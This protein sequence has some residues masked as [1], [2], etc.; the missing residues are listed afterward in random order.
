MDLKATLGSLKREMEKEVLAARKAVTVSVREEAEALKQTLRSQ[1]INA[2]LGQRVARAWRGNSYPAGRESLNAAA[3][4]FS[5]VPH[6]IDAY[7]N[8]PTIRSPKGMLAIPLPGLPKRINGKRPTPESLEKAWGV[9]LRPVFR[10]GKP[11]LLVIDARASRGKRGGF[12]APSAASQ[13]TGRG[14]A[15]VPAFVLLPSVKVKKRLR[16]KEAGD[17]ARND[18]GRRIV[19]NWNRYARAER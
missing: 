2:G 3:L 11:L 17:R 16:V 19:Q 1:T 6:I 18:L 9:K 15:V 5:K 12:K 10:P 4:L 7:E 14:A 13:R 8:A